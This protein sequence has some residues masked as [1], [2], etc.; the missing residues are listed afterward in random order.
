MIVQANL[1]WNEWTQS[2]VVKGFNLNVSVMEML[3]IS[4]G[5]SMV[6]TAGGEADRDRAK[7]M[8]ELIHK[9]MEVHS[10]TA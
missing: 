10:E 3:N 9:E 5:L 7:S 6:A 2:Y 1:T 8:L 4:E